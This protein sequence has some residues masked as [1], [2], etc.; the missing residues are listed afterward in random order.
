M[1]LQPG[2]E[3]AATGSSGAAPAA[4][5][6]PP[7]VHLGTSSGLVPVFSHEFPIHYRAHFIFVYRLFPFPSGGL[8][9]TSS[10]GAAWWPQAPQRQPCSTHV[11]RARPQAP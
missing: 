8:G 6:V 1:G 3:G 4:Q 9:S 7:S 11:S 5:A 2:P 10:R